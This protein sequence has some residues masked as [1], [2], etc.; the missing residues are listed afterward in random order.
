MTETLS[1][2]KSTAGFDLID[3]TPDFPNHPFLPQGDHHLV[4]PGAHGLPCQGK[5]ERLGEPLSFVPRASAR[6]RRK[7]SNPSF[8]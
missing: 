8:V 7:I 4:D 6:A 1:R 3:R 2:P 5:A